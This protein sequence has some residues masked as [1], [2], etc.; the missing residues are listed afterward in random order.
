MLP[1]GADPTS[2][3]NEVIRQVNAGYGDPRVL[4]SA[5]AATLEPQLAQLLRHRAH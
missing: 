4:A 2:E 1:Q 3:I 5:M